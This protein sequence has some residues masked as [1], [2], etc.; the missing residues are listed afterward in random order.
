MA[1]TMIMR[2]M[3]RMSMTSACRFS[4]P[5]QQLVSTRLMSTYYTSSHEY[6][7]VEGDIAT[8]GV[9]DHA[10]SLLGDIVHVD[11]PEE[12]DEVEAEDTFG[13]VE[14]VKAASDVYSPVSGEVMAFNE[15]LAD[16]TDL[17]NKDPEGEGWF[18]KVK[19]SSPEE[20]EKLMDA[21]AYKEH[22]ENEEH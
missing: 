6:V 20:V 13:S 15:K 18:V 1:S 22:C 12:G 9:T 4:A 8:I 10:Q 14:S 17:V 11:L 2:T 21:D 3:A 16:Q 5:S 7:K 19:L